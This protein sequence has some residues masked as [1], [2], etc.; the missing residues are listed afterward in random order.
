MSE[1]KRSFFARLQALVYGGHAF[2]HLLDTDPV[3]DVFSKAYQE[4]ENRGSLSSRSRSLLKN[5]AAFVALS[6]AVLFTLPSYPFDALYLGFK[7]LRE[8]AVNTPAFWFF[9]PV[10]GLMEGAFWLASQIVHAATAVLRALMFPIF[11][12]LDTVTYFWWSKGEINYSNVPRLADGGLFGTQTVYLKDDAKLNIRLD[13]LVDLAYLNLTGAP[14]SRW[15]RIGPGMVGGEYASHGAFATSL[16]LSGIALGVMEEEGLNVLNDVTD[17]VES[18]L[19]IFGL[20]DI[21]WLNIP[22][23]ELA[24]VIALLT[25]T[26]G[27]STLVTNVVTNLCM[28]DRTSEFKNNRWDRD[29]GGS[30][31]DPEVRNKTHTWVQA[32]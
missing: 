31:V 18:G 17:Q 2:R 26:V 27:V 15:A 6:K 23:A 10:F 12:L 9:A 30:L 20:E 3:Y 29:Y 22:G 16:A 21:N 28:T 14:S 4:N 13:V 5:F 8:K 24:V 1:D 11:M 25:L 7:S 32:C 19:E